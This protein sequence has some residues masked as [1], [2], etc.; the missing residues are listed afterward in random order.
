MKFTFRFVWQEFRR[1]VEPEN[2]TEYEY[3]DSIFNTVSEYNRPLVRNKTNDLYDAMKVHFNDSVYVFY[4]LM[5]WFKDAFGLL[6]EYMLTCM[7]TQ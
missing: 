2:K 6:Y 4:W 3:Y 7:Q 1:S 5:S